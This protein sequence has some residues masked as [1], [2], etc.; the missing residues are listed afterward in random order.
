MSKKLVRSRDCF[1]ASLSAKT[2]WLLISLVVSYY[3]VIDHYVEMYEAKIFI[4]KSFLVFILIL[5]RIFLAELHS[6]H[7]KTLKMKQPL[8]VFAK[9]FILDGWR[10]FNVP[11]SNRIDLLILVTCSCFL[12]VTQLNFQENLANSQDDL[13]P[14]SSIITTKIVMATFGSHEGAIVVPILLQ[15]GDIF[16]K[17]LIRI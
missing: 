14:I 17:A 12:V 11:F 16:Q 3:L 8:T 15:L 1:S 2:T 7:S 4:C 9:S 13:D 10:V 6:E 5:V